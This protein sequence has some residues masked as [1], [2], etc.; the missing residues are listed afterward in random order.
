MRL[1]RLW[2]D[3]LHNPCDPLE[4]KRLPGQPRQVTARAQV[5]LEALAPGGARLLPQSAFAQRVGWAIRS[6]RRHAINRV[7]LG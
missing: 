3:L 7:Y 6:I 2:G 1:L 4:Q 5:R